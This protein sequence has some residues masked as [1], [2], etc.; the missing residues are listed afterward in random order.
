MDAATKDSLKRMGLGFFALAM[1]YAL[2]RLCQWVGGDDFATAVYLIVFVLIGLSIY[3]VI[4]W[5]K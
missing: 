1:I 4:K 3:G 5:K 2:F